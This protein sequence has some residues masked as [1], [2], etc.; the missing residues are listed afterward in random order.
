MSPQE[1]EVPQDHPEPQQPKE[2]EN[3]LSSDEKE[4]ESPETE[5]MLEASSIEKRVAETT[6]VQIN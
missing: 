4:V 1:P 3:V 2:S 5:P 6:K